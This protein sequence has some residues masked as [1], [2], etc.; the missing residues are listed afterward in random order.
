[1]Y[2]AF[3]GL[4]FDPFLLNTGSRNP[5]VPCPF[6]PWNVGREDEDPSLAVNLD[7]GTYQCWSCGESDGPLKSKGGAADFLMAYHD[8]PLSTALAVRDL[9]LEGKESP[10]EAIERSVAEWHANLLR[11]VKMHVKVQSARG[12]TEATIKA[13]QIGWDGERVTIPITNYRGDVV[14]VRRYTFNKRLK[15]KYLNSKP[16]GISLGAKRLWPMEVVM[17]TTAPL[18]FF[19]G[20]WD[21]LLAYQMGITTAVTLTGGEGA[22]WD[23]AW[24]RHVRGREAWICYDV[25]KAGKAG[26]RK[27]ATLLSQAGATVHVVDLPIS[28]P[29]NADFTDYV[30]THGNGLDEFRTLCAATPA[31]TPPVVQADKP[32]YRPA[33]PAVAVSLTASTF[34]PV[35]QGQRVILE[36]Q[37]A[38]K[39]TSPYTIVK[40]AE[41]TCNKMSDDNPACAVCPLR[42]TGRLILEL[43]P[44]KDL[45]Q[46]IRVTDQQ[47]QGALRRL[48]GI[49][50]CPLWE[51]DVKESQNVEEILVTPR[52][53]QGVVNGLYT[54]HTLQTAYHFYDTDSR[55]VE[56]SKS[57]MFEGV[58]TTDPWKQKTIHVVDR[59]RPVKDSIQE[60]TLT[61]AMKARLRAAFTPQDTTVEATI[62]ALAGHLTD[63]VT[64]VIGRQDL[65]VAVLLGYCTVQQFAFLGQATDGLSDVLVIGDTRTG[66]SEVA[67]K[68]SQ[69]VRLGELVTGEAV[70]F[71]GLVGG[72]QQG[73]SG[74]WV[75]TWG[76]IP[77]NNGGLVFVDEASGMTIEQIAK[78]SGM[79]SRRVAS[80]I[81]IRTAE[82]AARTRQVWLT[83]PREAKVMGEYS[84]GVQAIPP[85]I[86]QPEDIARFDLV[87]SSAEGDVPSEEI[88]AF[89]DP[90][91]EGSSPF[92]ADT[93]RSLI[94]FAWSRRTDQV[95]FERAAEQACLDAALAMGKDYS[96]RIPLVE[97]ANHRV[98]MARLAAAAACLTYSTDESG[99]VVVVKP[100]HVLWVRGFMDAA[101]RKRSL[102][103]YGFSQQQSE[104]RQIAAAK[105]EE[106]RRWARGGQIERAVV[107]LI[108]RAETFRS[109]D[110]QDQLAM[111]HA[112]AA[113]IIKRLSDARMVD[114]TGANLF[115]TATFIGLLREMKEKGER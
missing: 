64:R 21:R 61:D 35:Y 8:V 44:D 77:L 115:K 15:A 33:E 19:A 70:S 9:I 37:V 7:E 106:I 78:M 84:F 87:V 2:G 80:I 92:D 73:A 57:Y 75:V 42:N 101:Y 85:L 94:L 103:Y 24:D 34:D 54:D 4:Y 17:E 30:V 41:L 81:K 27:L 79:R 38:G 16:G 67:L 39:D 74:N 105:R 83:N 28:T 40:R 5:Q 63:R 60:F 112:S 99:E 86:G 65:V 25:D 69:Y 14:N 1:M 114:R 108:D 72:T 31:W 18:I 95:L 76:R 55:H 59:A 96:P 47:K 98:K 91:D 110:L 93:L 43:T 53:E 88:N 104:D 51:I 11:A 52:A 32:V 23:A 68:L 46:L 66:K 20:E 89:R 100:E 109:Q 26:A 97:G 13:Q 6:H 10:F 58:R 36:A 56:D 29:E 45:L 62:N 3:W 90:D 102:D 50:N 107:D 111:D 71:A 82:T 12:L 49:P 22:S 113:A 48:A